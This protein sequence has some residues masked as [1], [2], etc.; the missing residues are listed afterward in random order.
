MT[1]LT[2]EAA[3]ERVQSDARAKL[4]RQTDPYLRERLHDLDDLANRLLHQLA[5]ESLYVEADALPDNAILVAR[6]MGPAAL[7]DYDRGRLRGLVLEDGGS[8]SHVAIIAR[9]LGIPCVGEVAN[10]TDLVDSGDAIII[11]GASGDIR[12]RPMPDVVTAYGEKARLRAKRQEQYHKPVSYTHLDVY[13]IQDI[14]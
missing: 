5:G 11:D 8:S 1:G 14:A 4:Q 7:L 2:A 10:I 6:T 12:I 13:K 3:V 9:A